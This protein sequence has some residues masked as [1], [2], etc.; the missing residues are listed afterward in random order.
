[1]KKVKVTQL[2]F[3]SNFETWGS[4]LCSQGY[5]VLHRSRSYRT[6]PTASVQHKHSA[7]LTLLAMTPF[8]EVYPGTRQPRW[9]PKQS[10]AVL[11]ELGRKRTIPRAAGAAHQPMHRG[12]K[13]LSCLNAD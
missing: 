8:Q 9:L 5:T 13:P 11:A 12:G 1:M 3:R 7:V 6:N 4:K 10:A 2:K